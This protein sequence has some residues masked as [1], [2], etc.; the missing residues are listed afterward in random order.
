VQ[1]GITLSYLK[2]QGSRYSGEKNKLNIN[3]SRYNFFS[4]HKG[5]TKAQTLH[6]KKFHI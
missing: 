4:Y 5:D 1:I 6:A 3:V 2:Q